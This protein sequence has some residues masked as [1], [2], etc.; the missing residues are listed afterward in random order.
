M[1]PYK[2]IYNTR[3]SEPAGQMLTIPHYNYKQHKSFTHLSNSFIYSAPRQWNSLPDTCGSASSLS[4]FHA[5]LKT[6]LW[7]K[8]FRP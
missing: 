7:T 8:S 4:S 2:S 1:Q 5:R 6:Y 3:R